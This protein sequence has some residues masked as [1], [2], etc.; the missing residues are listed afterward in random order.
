MEINSKVVL[1]YALPQAEKVELKVYNALGQVV[2]RLVEEYQSAGYHRVMWDGKD[3]VGRQVASGVFV[4][5]IQAGE[6]EK[7]QRVALVN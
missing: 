3:G 5:R 2:R 4:V 7:I 6:F 1:K